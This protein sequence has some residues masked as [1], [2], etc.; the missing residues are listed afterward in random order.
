MRSWFSGTFPRVQNP[1]FQP[2]AFGLESRCINHSTM[3]PH[4]CLP[5]SVCEP[6][7]MCTRVCVYVHACT[8]VIICTCMCRVSH[9]PLRDGGSMQW[10]GGGGGAA[11]GVGDRGSTRRRVGRAVYISAPAHM[12]TCNFFTVTWCFSRGVNKK[13]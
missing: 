7:Y 1:G 13:R 6:V 5:V 11:P 2:M 4:A 10:G 8:H 12:G 3:L 9:K